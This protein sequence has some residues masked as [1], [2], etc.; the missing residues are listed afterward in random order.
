[1]YPYQC[2]ME[3]KLKYVFP[4]LIH[5]DNFKSSLPIMYIFYCNGNQTYLDVIKITQVIIETP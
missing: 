2:I 5:K 1:M 3:L 4:S